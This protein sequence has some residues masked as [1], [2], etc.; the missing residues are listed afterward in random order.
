MPSIGEGFGIAFLEALACGVPVIG[1][2]QDGSLDALGDGALGIAIKP[3][4]SDELSLAIQAALANP[5]RDGNCVERFTLNAFSTHARALL[6]T[7]C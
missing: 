2:N 1:G 4:D 5:V 3:D 7:I 6:A